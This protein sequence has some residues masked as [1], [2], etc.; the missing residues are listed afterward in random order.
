MEF[1]TYC[2]EVSTRVHIHFFDTLKDYKREEQKVVD[3]EKIFVQPKSSKGSETLMQI[4]DIVILVFERRKSYNEAIKI[5]ASN[6]NVRKQTIIDKCTR[7]IGLNTAEFKT[8]L[9]DK[10]KLESFLL[11]IFPQ[12]SEIIVNRLKGLLNEADRDKID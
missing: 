3:E 5:V 2:E 6:R 8:L 9:Q 10:N 12:D 7:R 4:L 1:K 11:R